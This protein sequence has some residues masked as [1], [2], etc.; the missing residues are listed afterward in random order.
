MPTKKNGLSRENLRY[1]LLKKQGS[2]GNLGSSGNLLRDESFSS[3]MTP[4]RRS[5]PNTKHKLDASQSV[6]H[7]MHASSNINRQL[8]SS[9]HQGN[10]QW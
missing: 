6:P 1:G 10:A 4:K 3:R 7:M 8:P 9:G 5:A 2:R